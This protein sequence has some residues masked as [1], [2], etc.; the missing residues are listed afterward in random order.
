[1]ESHGSVW[2]V[3][4]ET[5]KS[6]VGYWPGVWVLAFGVRMVDVPERFEN[7]A[8][9]EVLFWLVCGGGLWLKARDG[10]E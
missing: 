5:S 9:N 4:S 8:A 3:R 7:C 6:V 10:G 2:L 1:M